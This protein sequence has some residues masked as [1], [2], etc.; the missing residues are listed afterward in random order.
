MLYTGM[1]GGGCSIVVVVYMGAGAAFVHKRR[2]CIGVGGAWGVVVLYR[3][4]GS[5]A[6]FVDG[7][8][9]GW[10]GAVQPCTH[11]RS[12]H[13]QGQRSAAHSEAE[14]S[15]AAHHN[16]GGQLQHAPQTPTLA[17]HPTPWAGARPTTRATHPCTTTTANKQ[18]TH[19]RHH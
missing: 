5:Q 11:Q 16:S 19:T 9:F 6:V 7:G 2:V 8:F 3:G 13:V 15:R 12:M 4:G 18:G 10:G 14:Q 17:Q 1:G